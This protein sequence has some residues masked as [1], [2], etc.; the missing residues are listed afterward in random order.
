MWLSQP[1]NYLMLPFLWGRSYGFK[2]TVKSH[3]FGVN[4]SGDSEAI[5]RWEAI[6]KGFGIIII[7]LQ[8]WCDF[9]S[10]AHLLRVPEPSD[11]TYSWVVVVVL[12][13]G[14]CFLG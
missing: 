3:D 7:T 1:A 5:P 14:S 13:G 2:C 11:M 8:H 6:L 10:H 4:R 9:Y 12:E